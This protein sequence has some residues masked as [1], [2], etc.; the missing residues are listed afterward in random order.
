MKKRGARIE[1]NVNRLA[2]RTMGAIIQTV[3]VATPVDTGRARGNW[4]A[5]LGTGIST[6]SPRTDKSGAA[7][8]AQGISRIAARRAGQ[9][10]H[11]TNNLP[12]IGRLDEGHSAQAPAGFIERA[13]QVGV[14]AV[15]RGRIVD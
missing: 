3:T 8:I 4:Q 5:S 13:V 2:V 7:T 15:N 11:L 9:D 1:K 6:T 10:I 14:N 12:Y